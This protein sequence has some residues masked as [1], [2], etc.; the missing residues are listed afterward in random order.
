MSSNNEPLPFVSLLI[1]IRNEDCHLDRCLKSVT[2]QDYPADLLE[3]LISDGMSTDNTRKIIK[4]WEQK[5]SRISLFDNPQ[6]IVPTGLNVLIPITN[7]D[8]IIRIDGHCIIDH[9]YVTNCVRHLRE[10]GVDGVGGP[11]RTVG[12][13]FISEVIA[14]AMSSKFGVGDSSFRTESGQTKLV[15]TVPFPAYTREIIEK[16]GLY[17]EELVRNQ[18]DEYNY[19]IRGA[20]GKILLAEDVRSTYFSRGSISKL[21]K[22]YYQYGYWKVRVMQKHLR[23]MSLRQF[24]PPAFVLSIIV[25]IILAFTSTWGWLVLTMIAGLYLVV[26]FGCSLLIAVKN[27]WHMLGLLP[28]A[29]TI[30][31]ISYGA[32]FLAGLI[33]FA[34]RWNDKAGKVPTLLP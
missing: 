3:I 29:F 17:D 25:S 21:W 11:M 19:R 28:I 31:H 4:N 23:Q 14:A 5:D 20:G 26:N 13:D 12:E 27:S 8:V 15:D 24:V 33:K 18:D 22:Q 9:D 1:P 2:Q 34:N 6:K 32:G 7:G 10:D 16:V 30:I